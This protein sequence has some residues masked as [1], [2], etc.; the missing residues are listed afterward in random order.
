MIKKIYE[1]VEKYNDQHVTPAKGHTSYCRIFAVDQHVSGDRN[2]PEIV[3][4]MKECFRGKENI[5]SVKF[6][7]VENCLKYL[8][9]FTA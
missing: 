5:S 4:N 3:L 1:L 8:E 7:K 2:V 9:Y 6:A